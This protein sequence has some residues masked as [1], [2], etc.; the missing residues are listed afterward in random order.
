MHLTLVALL[1]LLSIACE[2]IPTNDEEDS[3]IPLAK[4]EDL[5]AETKNLNKLLK[6]EERPTNVADPFADLPGTGKTS[7]SQK[8]TDS[9]TEGSATQT[10]SDAASQGSASGTKAPST[11]AAGKGVENKTPAKPAGKAP[12][13]G[14]TP[15]AKVDAPRTQGELEK[16][17]KTG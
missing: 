7:A 12:D 5:R 1:C 10:A 15:P 6:Q 4:A 3:P 14:K 8:R 9:P 13:K 17:R 2:F 16:K 11:S